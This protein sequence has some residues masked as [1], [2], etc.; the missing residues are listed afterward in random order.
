MKLRKA[1]KAIRREEVTEMS[2]YRKVLS[3]FGS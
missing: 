1:V 3:V 2:E